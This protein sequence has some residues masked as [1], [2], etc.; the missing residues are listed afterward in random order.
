M[1]VNNPCLEFWF[2]LHFKKTSKYYDTCAEAKT[3]LK[4]YLKNYEKTRKFFT[5]QGDDIYLKLK[6]RLKI[7]VENSIALGNYDKKNPKKQCVKWNCFFNQA[8]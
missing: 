2:L 8:N 5:K 4:K 6:P 3:E 1:I 7:A